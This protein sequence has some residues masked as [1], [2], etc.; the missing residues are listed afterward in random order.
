[1]WAEGCRLIMF[2]HVVDVEERREARSRFGAALA[3]GSVFLLCFLLRRGFSSAGGDLLVPRDQCRCSR[4]GSSWAP[5]VCLCTPGRC[6]FPALVSP[7]WSLTLCSAFLFCLS[8]IEIPVEWVG[9]GGHF[10][11]RLCVLDVGAPAA[12]E[13]VAIPGSPVRVVL[14]LWIWCAWDVLCG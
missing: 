8:V 4:A 10:V 5:L 6:W 7:I 14:D 11:V 3:G 2:C 1:M 9:G 12:H 13:F